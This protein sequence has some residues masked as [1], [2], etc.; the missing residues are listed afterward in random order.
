MIPLNLKLQDVDTSMPILMEGKY[1]VRI[2]K[3]ELVES[4]KNAGSFNLKVTYELVEDAVGTKGEQ[5][6]AGFQLTR[7]YPI[8]PYANGE[9]DESFMKTLTMFQLAACGLENK[10][11]NV[12][13]LPDFDQVFVANLP[14]KMV[15][16]SI[17]TS[18]AK[19]GDEYGP[20]SEIGSVTAIK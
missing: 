20:K 13:Q 2:T 15:M 17:R 3:T 14:G 10:P 4:Q 18:K 9:H 19:E 12:K 8:P 5:I 16:A 11:E 6:K 7:Y 1:P